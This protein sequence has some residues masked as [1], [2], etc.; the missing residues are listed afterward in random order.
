MNFDFETILS[1]V[2]AI[3]AK[4]IPIVSEVSPVITLAKDAIAAYEAKDEAALATAQ[5]NAQ[6]LANSLPPPA[7]P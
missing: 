3:A 7:A 5:T 2:L 6:A 4:A 1:D